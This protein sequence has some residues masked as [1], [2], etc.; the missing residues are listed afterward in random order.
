MASSVGSLALLAHHQHNKCF[1]TVCTSCLYNLLC[2]KIKY[3][4]TYLQYKIH[5]H[6]WVLA[7]KVNNQLIFNA[8]GTPLAWLSPNWCFASISVLVFLLFTMLYGKSGSPSPDVML[9]LSPRHVICSCLQSTHTHT[10]SCDVLM[11]DCVM[12]CAHACRCGHS[13]DTQ[14]CNYGALSADTLVSSGM[15]IFRN[16]GIF[17]SLTI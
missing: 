3:L 10:A 9:V 4:L 17:K 8:Q 14:P 6:C 13:P 15:R 12:W 16:S 11:L 7:R 2:L 5:F 1:H